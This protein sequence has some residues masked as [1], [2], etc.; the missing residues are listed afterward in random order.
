MVMCMGC[1]RCGY[2]EDLLGMMV[3]KWRPSIDVIRFV[4]RILMYCENK[5][6]IKTDRS[7]WYRWTLQRL[8]LKHEYETFG[9]RNAIEG[10]FNILKAQKILE[11]FSSQYIKEKCRKLDYRIC[12]SLQFGGENFLTISLALSIDY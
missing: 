3:T 10:W 6:V 5:P 2:I 12:H 1:S 9:E 8:G 4:R 7:P 11:T